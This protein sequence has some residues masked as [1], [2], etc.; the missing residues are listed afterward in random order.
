MLAL[1]MV[2]T[3]CGQGDQDGSSGSTPASARHFNEADV[4]F[5]QG[6]IPLQRQAARMSA[7][8]PARTSDVGVLGLASRIGG[9]QKAW[10]DIMSG[11]LTDWGHEVREGSMM[12]DSRMRGMMGA[13]DMHGMMRRAD[14]DALRAKSE[15]GFDQKFLTMMVRHHRG[16][17]R[18]AKDESSTGADPEARKHATRVLEVQGAELEE[19]QQMMRP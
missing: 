17:I 5:A 10:I 8:A 3:G 12:D 14:F 4:R 7:M 15:V 1:S 2:L 9:T 6:M 13:G 19:M 16:T 11:R 18:L